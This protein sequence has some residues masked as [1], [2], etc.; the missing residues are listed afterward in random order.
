[1]R[2][3]TARKCAL[4][5][6]LCLVAGAEVRADTVPWYYSSTPVP[7]VLSADVPGT[8][9]I[10]LSGV[11]SGQ[12][13]GDS[14]IVLANLGTVSNADPSNPATFTNANYKL[15]LNILDASTSQS[16]TMFF[17]GQINGVLSS[18]NALILNNFTGQTTQ[19]QTI[20]GHVYTVTIGPFAPPGVPG[21]GFGSI[22]ALA[23]VAVSDAPEPSTLALSGLALS[24]F[25]AGWWRRRRSAR[26]A[27]TAAA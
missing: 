9:Q 14:S 7:G 26:A 24:V 8:G 21:V 3:L 25:G 18:G 17:T 19:T 20:G 15:A 5:L 16:G 1:M 2:N 23:R 6:A 12:V 4:A 11:I 13:T 27:A 22:S 10:N